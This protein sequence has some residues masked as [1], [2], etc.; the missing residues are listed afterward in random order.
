LDQFP[1]T[2]GPTEMEQAPKKRSGWKKAGRILL[3]TVL[4]IFFLIVFVFLLILTPPVQSFLRKKV[5]SFLENKLDT[6]V[7][8]GRIYIGLPKNVVL[9]DVYVEDRQRDTLFSGGKLKTNIDIWRLITKN[10]VI[11]NSIALEGITA[12][13]KRELPDTTFNFQFIIDAFA[14]APDTGTTIKDTSAAAITLGKI[15]LDHIR[16]LYKDVITGNDMEASL[17]HLDTRVD[18]FDPDK[19]HFDVPVTNIRGLTARVYQSKPLATPE[20]PSK[21]MQEAVAPKP[22]QID[23]GKIGLENIKVDFRNDVS[24]MYSNI[25]IGKLEVENDQID[26]NKRLIQLDKVLL[27]GTK[28]S[29]RLGKKEAAKVIVKEVE[30]E[31][32]SQA[33]A[34]WTVA[35]AEIDLDK[36][37]IRFDNDNSPSVQKGMNYAHLDARELTLKASNFVLA[38]DSVAGE[39]TEGSVKEK[40]GFDLEELRTKFLYTSRGASL[41]DLYIKTPG[42]ELRR[43]ASIRYASIESIQKDIGN[44]Q[45]DLDIEDSRLL[46]KDVL[47]FA[48]MLQQQPAFADPNAVW[49]LNSRVTGR[50]SDLRI[51]SLQLQGLQQTKV[52]V[53]GSIAGLPEMKNMRADLTIRNISSSRKDISRFLPPN[54]LPQNITL[55]ARLD[56][57]GTIRGTSD[58]MNVDLTLDTDLGDAIVRGSFHEMDDPKKMGYH[59]KIDVQAMEVGTIIQNKQMLGPVSAT[60]TAKG[61]GVDP[62]YA[63]AKF[64]GLIRSVFLNGYQYTGLKLDGSLVNQQLDANISMKDA[65]IDFALNAKADL[66]QNTPALKVNGMIDSLKMQELRLSKD[67]MIFRGKIDADFPVTDPDKL[68]GS[69]MITQALFVHKD[70]RVNLDTVQLIAGQ[71]DTSRFLRL[72]SDFASANLE[73][74]YQLTQLGSIFQQAIQPYFA[75]GPASTAVVAKPYDFKL[76]VHVRDNPALKALVPGLTRIDAVTFQSRFSDRD[77]WSASLRAPSIDMGA[78]QIRNLYLTAGT[79]Q[80]MIDIVTTIGQF[81]S[82]PNVRLNNTS[83]TA[84]V[85]D[86][87]I[88]FTLNNRD[89]DQKDKYNI[90]GVL[91]QPKNGE[92]LFMVR[93]QGLVLNYDIWQVNPDNRILLGAS[94][95]NAS[96]FSLSRE[97][98]Q[99]SINSLAAGGNAPLEVNFSQF[100]LATITGFVVTDSTLVDGLLN[101]KVTFNNLSNEFVFVGDLTINDL[102]LRGDTVG[103]VK[104]LVNNQTADTYAADITLSGRGNDLRMV[105]NYYLRSGDS[106]FDFDLDI[107]NLPMT[108]AQAFSNDMIRNATGFVNGKFDITGTIKRPLVRGDLNFNKAGFN[109]S[110]LNSYFTIDQEKIVVNEEGLRFNR[111]EIK[112][113]AQNSLRI[114]GLAATTNFV[115]YKFDLGIVTNNFRAL[116]STKKDN[117]LFYGQLYFNTNLKV[118][119]TET[120]PAID[121]RLVVNDKT[122]MTVVLPQ[123]EPGVVDREGIV[124]FVDFDAPLNDSLFL[125]A[126]DSLNTAPITGMDI[127]ANIEISKDAEFSLVIDEGNG[128]FLNVKGE[129]LLTA[130]IDPSG[131][132]NMAGSYELE[133]GSYELTFN[134][135]KRKFNIEKGSRIVWEG[136]PTKARVD[137]NAIYVANAAPLDLVK[138]QLDEN[139]TAFTRNTY[140]QKLPF[141][142]Y[143]KMEGE[144]LKP[145]ISFDI[146]LPEQR[147]YAVAGEIL[148]TVRTKLDQLRLEPGEMNKQVFSLLLLNRFIA[149]NPFESGSGGGFNAGVLARQSVSKLLTEQLNKLAGDLVAGVDL[150]FDVLSSEDYT[151]GERRDRTDLN[152]GLSKQLLNDRLTVSVG[153]N[154]ELEGPRNANAQSSNIAGNVAVDYQLSRDNRYLLRAYRKNEYQ[155]VID[156]YIIETGVGFIINVD[157][158]RFREIFLSKRERDKRRQRRREQRELQE[159]QQSEQTNHVTDSTSVSQ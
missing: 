77:G 79:Q 13:I 26:L 29:I 50:V 41:Q 139:T 72:Q 78:N 117:K 135:I 11:I 108:T 112:D 119:G 149:D 124:E 71:K 110:M 75:M 39:I 83:I 84:Q 107:R 48:P 5:V 57:R 67:R 20:P 10:E 3:K 45:V 123:R 136:E 137:L 40:S 16:V 85:A 92:Y 34:G 122:K 18:T 12:K 56:T 109:L 126:Y 21:D 82:G 125:A 146:V 156:G 140:L 7:D 22:M 55:P 66:A 99:L 19:L 159:Q 80:D 17:E 132:V 91:Q 49:Y 152:V 89:R 153:S 14:P 35:V 150:N 121:G 70:Q 62:K 38:T 113:S 33:A 9:E 101:G 104:M 97:G 111:F 131:K 28:A 52:D 90:S 155:G 58:Q 138:N 37:D 86:N 1:F 54:T 25:D 103:N 74:R 47:M 64:D 141:D 44:M 51:N 8:I 105:G 61:N 98:Q 133:Q 53:T 96:K 114:D 23:F 68:E 43:H 120:A 143:L 30:Q 76:D 158:N 127:A 94:G 4:W 93:P 144:L 60:F 6:R 69:L 42:T 118:K 106:N 15:E 151:T 147:K 145:E 59:A 154:F 27:A 128:D 31:V 63:V 24:A 116:N 46:V 2:S 65:N 102:S 81:S 134:F 115:N 73:G 142:V 95:V 148:T 32:E 88:N 100:R 129:A 87:T 36:N 157:Y 130:G